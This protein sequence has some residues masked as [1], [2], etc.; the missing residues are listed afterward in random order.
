MA[1]E[2]SAVLREWRDGEARF[3]GLAYTRNYLLHAPFFKPRPGTVEHG[4]QLPDTISKE[5]RRLIGAALVSAHLRSL[6]DG[7]IAT[8]K[9]SDGCEWPSRRNVRKMA[10]GWQA[11]SEFMEQSPPRWC[12]SE[13]PSGF[14]LVLAEP[15][16][17]EPPAADFFESQ[18]VTA[19]RLFAGILTSEW[20]QRLCQCQYSLCGRYFVHSKLR[21]SYRHGTFCSRPHRARAS[22]EALTRARR[23]QA[24]WQLIEAAAQWLCRH[25]MSAWQDNRNF[26]DR[27][28][29]ALSQKARTNPNLRA[30]RE[31]VKVNWVTRNRTAIEK[32]RLELSDTN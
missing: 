1:T 19:R 26:K 22:A 29:T 7:W 13:D 27:L 20:Q 12:P 3:A 31:P 14:T 9:E 6:V 30:G 16:W 5:H 4:W 21:A 8:G 11:V 15:Q 17:G 23:Q 18:Q 2:F 10:Q 28:A 24:R 32:R 25:P